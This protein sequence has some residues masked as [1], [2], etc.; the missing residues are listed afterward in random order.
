VD[1]HAAL[2]RGPGAPARGGDDARP[3]DQHGRGNRLPRH[4]PGAGRGQHRGDPSLCVPR[5]GLADGAGGLGNGNTGVTAWPAPIGQA[6]AFDTA[7]Q[8][9]FGQAIGQEFVQKGENVWLAPNVNMARYPL[10]GR[11]FEAYGEDPYLSGQTAVAGIQGVQ[12][13]H[14]IATSKHYLANNSETNRNFESSNM[15]DRT[16]HEIYLPAFEAAVKQG[17]AGSVMC[18]YNRVNELYATWRCRPRSRSRP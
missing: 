1:E 11:T 13:R 7:T 12:S 6:A 8:K 3:E 14:V 5:L 2:A 16:M 10:N 15:D 17:K 9:A 18:A 4:W